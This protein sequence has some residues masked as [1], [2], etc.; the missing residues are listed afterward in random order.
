[1]L[2]SSR[3][4]SLFVCLVLA[5]AAPAGPTFST[6][7]SSSDLLALLGQDNTIGFAYAGNKFVGSVYFG[8]NNNQLYQTDLN[9]K[10]LALF[11]PAIP[12]VSGEIWVEGSLG[13]GGFPSRDIY[14]AQNNGV[15]HIPNSGVGGS[16]FVSGL[17]GNVRGIAFD[18]FGLYGHDMLVTTT[19]G[20]VYRVNSA[21]VATLLASTGED[22]E[23]LDFTADAFGPYPA[24]T[25]LVTSEGTGSVRAISPAGVITLVATVPGAETISFVPLNLGTGNPALEGFYGADYPVDVVKAPA[26]DF[27]GFKG[28]A[29]VTGEFSHNVDQIHWNGSS[30][31]VTVLGNYPNQPEDAI[32]VTAAIINP[33][34]GP[35]PEPATML[36]VGAGIGGLALIRRRRTA[37]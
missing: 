13:L 14:A 11:G 17:V 26:S 12:G 15:F 25:L 16:T 2:K 29:I 28:D 9:G 36:L 33:G 4:L 37:S 31:D 27:T 34:P 18:P 21:G 24:G 30:F 35:V 1:M 6:F 5:R 22:T 23:G 19:S 10:N 7:V 32:F 8:A 3:I 20:N